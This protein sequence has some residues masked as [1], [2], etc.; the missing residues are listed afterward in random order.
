MPQLGTG[1]VSLDMLQHTSFP[2]NCVPI[3]GHFQAG[4]FHTTVYAKKVRSRATIPDHII[5]E[6]QN[7][8]RSVQQ[9]ERSE[10]IARA[11][12]EGTKGIMGTDGSVQDPVATYSF[13]IPISQTDVKPNA[14]G[15]GFFPPSAQ[16][17]DPADSQSL[18]PQHSLFPQ[19]S[20]TTWT[21]VSKQL[22]LEI[23]SNVPKDS[24]SCNLLMD[25]GHS[26]HL[27]SPNNDCH[28]PLSKCLAQ[29]A[30]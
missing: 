2:E 3:S 7:M 18:F 15:G 29:E 20:R 10:T 4:I 21:L 24:T 11:I 5:V 23:K 16:Q 27:G 25:A 30:S 12:W 17:Q 9:D 6:L 13:V 19:Q 28:E 22:F 1:L 8:N 14:R 26:S